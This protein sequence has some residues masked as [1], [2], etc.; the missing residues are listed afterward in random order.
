MNKSF[1]LAEVKE[2]ATKDAQGAFEAILSAAT[3]DRD[4]E[5]IDKGAFDPL[6]GSIPIH[7][8]HDFHDPVGKGESF[9]EDDVLKVRG[10]FAS[11]PRAQ[12]IRTLVS[13]GVIGSM[14]V[15]F[16]GADRKDG[17]DGVHIK[18][19]ELLE[20]SF[21]S[22]PSNREAAVLL[23]KEYA[24][25]VGARNS[26]KDQERIQSMHDHA[27][28]LGAAC[29]GVARA[30]APETEKSTST[31]PDGSAAPAAEPLADVNVALA[32]ALVAEAEVSLL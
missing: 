22:I 20:G 19:A 4:G 5:I 17:E 11:T 25:K 21:V 16:M 2:V 29:A 10:V 8:F 9:Y 32:Q 12:E 27:V 6:P 24:E 18:S 7:A 26:S 28:E 23:A 31:D 30:A 15:G 3:L 14:S 1:V 13:E